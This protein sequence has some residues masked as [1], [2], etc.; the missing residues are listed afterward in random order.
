MS[1]FEK[2]FH[3]N[4]IEIGHEHSEHETELLDEN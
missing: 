2:E 4:L 1:T 3:E